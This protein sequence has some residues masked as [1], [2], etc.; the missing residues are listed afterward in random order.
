LGLQAF[1]SKKYYLSSNSHLLPPNKPKIEISFDSSNQK[2][3]ITGSTTTD[4]DSLDE[5]LIYEIN[6][7]TSTE[8]DPNNWVEYKN[9]GIVPYSIDVI[10]PNSYTV[11][12]RVKDE[13]QNISEDITNWSFPDDYVI[14]ASQNI[15]ETSG[16]PNA[17][18]VAQVFKAQNSGYVQGIKVYMDGFYNGSSG[19]A[20][21]FLY[22]TS[23]IQ[24]IAQDNL[25]AESNPINLSSGFQ[26]LSFDF[27]QNPLL[28]KDKN[29]IWVVR[30]NHF[31]SNLFGIC[32]DKIG[33]IGFAAFGGSGWSSGCNDARTNYYF[34]LTG[35]K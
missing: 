35:S 26:Y 31:T 34:I 14:I 19:Y 11:A 23:D 28:E 30:F 16:N 15:K 1:D 18:A 21:S 33:G 6:Y 2:L 3:N 27:N 12:L 9:L 13:F 4:P 25:I 22:D 29:Y 10:Y 32:Q 5:N 20:Q 24:N 7:S 8:L 17:G